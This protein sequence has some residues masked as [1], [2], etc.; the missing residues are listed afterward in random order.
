MFE[1]KYSRRNDQEKNTQQ[2]FDPVLFC[3]AFLSWQRFFCSPEATFAQ[4]GGE[5]PNSFLVLHATV[6]ALRLVFIE[7]V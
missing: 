6:P 7:V 2:K 1:L 4:D 5:L 3:C